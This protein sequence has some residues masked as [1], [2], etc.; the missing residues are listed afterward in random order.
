MCPVGISS[1][2]K[3]QSVNICEQIFGGQIG[4]QDGG[5]VHVNLLCGKTMFY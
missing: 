2:G 1:F 5:H 4:G 3:P